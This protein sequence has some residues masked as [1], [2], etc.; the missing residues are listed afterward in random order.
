MGET[1]LKKN[2]QRT[3]LPG[4]DVCRW[5][6]YVNILMMHSLVDG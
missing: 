1:G 6:I 4:R 3:E 5:K 2:A